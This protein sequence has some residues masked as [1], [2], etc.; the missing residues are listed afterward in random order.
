MK[1]ITA[2]IPAGR[3]AFVQNVELYTR[4]E[5]K[6]ILA[7]KEWDIGTDIY[8]ASQRNLRIGWLADFGNGDGIYVEAI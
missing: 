1:T 3:T 6:T 7:D 2:L 4:D 8:S 5:A